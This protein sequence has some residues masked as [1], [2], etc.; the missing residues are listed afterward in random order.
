MSVLKVNVF[1][2]KIAELPV[3]KRVYMNVINFSEASIDLLR[4]YIQDGTLSPDEEELQKC[5]I[6]EALPKY[7]SGGCLAP[8]M[9][10]IKN[11]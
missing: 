10:Y 1:K 9:T 11:K 7:R 4:K 2:K 8:Q 3:G 6:P 5:I